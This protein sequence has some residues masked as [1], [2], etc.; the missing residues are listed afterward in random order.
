[1]FDFVRNCHISSR[2]ASCTFI[3]EPP[4][5]GVIIGF[6]FCHTDLS[7]CGLA[8]VVMPSVFAYV[9]S[10]SLHVG[11]SMTSAHFLT[12]LLSFSLL[13]FEGPLWA[14]WF[15]VCNLLPVCLLP[16]LCMC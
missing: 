7:H 12:A 5:S 2:M 6:Y 13:S 14:M 4:A 11:L 3:R 1:M 8:W 9:C 10:P 15:A 16:V